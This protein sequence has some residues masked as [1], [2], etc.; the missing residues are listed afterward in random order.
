MLDT[1]TFNRILGRVDRRA[2]RLRA[3]DVGVR[4]ISGVGQR[5]IGPLAAVSKH[6]IDHGNEILGVRR[7]IP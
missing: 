5:C 4:E 7:L 6:A 1:N 3:T 2:A